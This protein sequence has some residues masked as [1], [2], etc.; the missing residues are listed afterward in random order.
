MTKPRIIIPRMSAR[1]T[2]TYNIQDLRNNYLSIY[3]FGLSNALAVVSQQ[4]QAY[5]YSLNSSL[6]TLTETTIERTEAA[7]SVI[8]R[9]MAPVDEY[10]KA[11]TQKAGQNY[12]RGFPLE[13]FQDATGWTEDFMA[14]ASIRDMVV[15]TDS[16]QLA[17]TNE[18]RIGLAQAVYTPVQRILREYVDPAL[19]YQTLTGQ[20]IMP[21]FNGDGEIPSV[22]PSGQAFDGTHT[23]YTAVDTL[24]AS[25]VDTLTNNVGEHSTGNQIV[26]Y[27]NQANAGQVRALTGF[28]PATIAQ[29]INPLT[30]AVTT[31][32]LDVTRTDDKFLGYTA[33]GI[34]VY[35]KPWALLN[36]LLCFNLN[37]P[38]IIKRRVSK[39]PMLQGLRIKGV[40]GEVNLF[41][42]YW[43][44]SFG[45][46]VSSRASGAVLYFGP[47]PTGAVV[48]TYVAPVFN[49]QDVY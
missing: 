26:I 47:R 6:A 45:F 44:D 7:P 1:Q 28:V 24:A 14:G 30:G 33:G 19:G 3:Q 20:F 25:D 29:V 36:Y 8:S 11:R 48:A 40:N 43:E 9:R 39:I 15:M 4:L 21:L 38:K 13:R 41:A 16:V 23:H 2:G 37:G 42:Q 27:I 22:G 35:I 5:N 12:G 10:G 49:D 17:H 46:G 34:P 32:N 18:V 31:A